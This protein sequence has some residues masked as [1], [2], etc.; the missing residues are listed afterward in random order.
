MKPA[1]VAAW[2]IAA[3]ALLAGGGPGVAEP[4]LP[5]KGNRYEG[6][7]RIKPTSQRPF[8]LLG[9]QRGSRDSLRTH[10]GKLYLSLPPRFPEGGEILVWDR[11]TDYRMV[12]KLER[13][14]DGEA[15]QHWSD[16]WFEWPT[17]PARRIVRHRQA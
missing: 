8:G 2:V 9:L 1:Y 4:D 11:K 15:F 13:R 16:G 12:P 6:I 17:D 3:I 7:R 5:D 10:T 14:Q